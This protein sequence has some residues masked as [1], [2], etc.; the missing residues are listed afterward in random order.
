MVHLAIHDAV[1]AIEGRPFKS[2]AEYA[3]R[4]TPRLRLTLPS[5]PLR[6]TCW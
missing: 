5:P 2:Y 1:N 6:T 3:E 4:R